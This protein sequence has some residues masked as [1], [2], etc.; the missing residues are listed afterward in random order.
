[1][2]DNARYS[3]LIDERRVAWCNQ[4]WVFGRC[5]NNRFKIVATLVIYHYTKSISSEPPIE[6]SLRYR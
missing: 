5:K 3:P 4:P 1:M 6:E 2:T